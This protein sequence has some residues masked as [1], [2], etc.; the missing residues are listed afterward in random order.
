MAVTQSDRDALATAIARGYRTVQ[1]TDRR[2]VYQSTEAML[3]ALAF[4]DKELAGSATGGR[5]WKRYGTNKGLR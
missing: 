4:I 3:K 5:N 1:Y 2:I